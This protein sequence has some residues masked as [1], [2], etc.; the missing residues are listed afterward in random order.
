MEF[1]MMFDQLAK[2]RRTLAGSAMLMSV[3]LASCGSAEPSANSSTAQGPTAPVVSAAAPAKAEVITVYR[4]PNCGC[5]SLWGEVARRA[6]YEVRVSDHPDMASV[7]QRH[8]V[9]A[10]LASCH[11]SVVGGYVVEGHVPMEDVARLLRE[12]PRDIKGIAVA[13]M[14]TGSPGMEGSNG[15][16]Q[17]FE[18][19]AFDANG[20]TRVYRSVAG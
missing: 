20:R 7:K 19:V 2:S 13:G 17:P 11:T 8:G 5:C 18:V 9:P 6:G 3:L 4:D 12:R 15:T 1:H 16:T 10:E 14:P